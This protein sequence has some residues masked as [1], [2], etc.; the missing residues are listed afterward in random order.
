[1]FQYNIYD[2]LAEKGA[3]VLKNNDNLSEKKDPLPTL[4]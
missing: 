4:F 3:L 2:N 1:M